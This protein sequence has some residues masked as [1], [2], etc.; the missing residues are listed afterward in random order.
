MV[1]VVEVDEVDG[2]VRVDWRVGVDGAVK[3][4]GLAVVVGVI[5]ENGSKRSPDVVPDCIIKY[6]TT[7][8]VVITVCCFRDHRSN[9]KPWL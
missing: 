8:I 7:H 4:V 9:T 5:R 1:E 3:V 2:E 6:T